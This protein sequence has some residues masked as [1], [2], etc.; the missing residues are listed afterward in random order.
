M[1]CTGFAWLLPQV[2][3]NPDVHNYPKSAAL[4]TL[5]SAS[6][7]TTSRLNAARGSGSLFFTALLQGLLPIGAMV[8]FTAAAKVSTV[9]APERRRKLTGYIMTDTSIRTAADA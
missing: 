8:L 4:G 7:R 5:G 6:Q 9:V 3:C 2:F 1:I